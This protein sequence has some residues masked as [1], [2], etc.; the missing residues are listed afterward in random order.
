MNVQRAKALIEG[1]SGRRLVVVGDMMLDRFVWGAV[2]RIS[3]E[4][5]V[6][7]VEV[8]RES[9]HLG[10]AANVVANVVAL[11]GGACPVGVVGDDGNADLLEAELRR[12]GVDA[13]AL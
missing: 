1:F 13:T 7:V 5:P 10:G 2:R 8:E 3:P 9:Q 11:G 6:P 12:A 4:A